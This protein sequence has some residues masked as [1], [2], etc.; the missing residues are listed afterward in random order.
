MLVLQFFFINEY[1]VAHGTNGWTN[2]QQQQKKQ[3]NN[4]SSTEKCAVKQM[5]QA[6]VRNDMCYARIRYT[7]RLVNTHAHTSK[8]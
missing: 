1:I 7:H 3:D 2:E 6:F 8:F 5:L 4:N